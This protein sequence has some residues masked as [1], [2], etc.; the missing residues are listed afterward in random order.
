M[1]EGWSHCL[2]WTGCGES[3]DDIPGGTLV[4]SER[5]SGC[6]I[7]AKE[8]V[9]S[10][11]HEL[12]DPAR[13]RLTTWLIDQRRQTAVNP[14]VTRNVLE[15]VK[16]SRPLLVSDRADRVL[17][18]LVDLSTSIGEPVTVG[19]E[20]NWDSFGYWI[21]GSNVKSMQN[22]LAISE[23]Q[24]WSEV[25]FLIQYLEEQG[26]VTR[27]NVIPDDPT[28]TLTVEGHSRIA[29][30]NAN[31]ASS[32]AFVAMWFH[33]NLD[34]VYENGF[35]PAIRDAGYS[36]FIIDRADF[37]NKIEDE[38]VA[39]IRRSKFLVADFTH[40]PDGARGSVYY[41]A[42]FA[43]GF[44]LHVIFTCRADFIEKLHFDTN[45][46]P[47]IAWADAEDLRKKLAY[48]I[49][50]VIGEGPNFIAGAAQ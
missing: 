31:V 40:G 16:S 50:A 15:G 4:R 10:I 13:A 2:I 18:H 43:H 22:V 36:P 42:G 35:E 17:K 38:I 30:T 33:P 48:R 37:I 9:S 7:V 46:Y 44:G 11:R 27:S 14:V 8:L 34:E 21:G 6:Y 29:E 5:T 19:D 20:G 3:A 47:H 25:A 39:E 12:D 49:R 28:C 41:E 23:S 32:Q 45:H 24:R 1:V 26:W